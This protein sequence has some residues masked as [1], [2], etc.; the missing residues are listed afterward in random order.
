MRE[1]VFFY[2]KTMKYIIY[3]AIIGVI[4]MLWAR[5]ALI[6][7]TETIQPKPF[8]E[9]TETPETNRIITIL[10]TAY[11]E[12][13]SCHYEN[14]IMAN[15]ERAHVGAIA[16]NFLPLETEVEIDGVRYIVKDRHAKWLE[17]RIDIFMGYGEEAYQDAINYGKKIK[18]VKVF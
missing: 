17:D 2:Y 9:A 14:C 18:I 4:L 3:L 16:C 6:I 13:D 15:G 12:L 10:T 5:Q 8:G 11:S 1:M 7:E